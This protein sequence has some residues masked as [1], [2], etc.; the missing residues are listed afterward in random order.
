MLKSTRVIHDVVLVGGSTRIPRVHQLLRNFFN[1][2]E[3]CKSTNPDEA[4]AYGA[5]VQAAILGSEGNIEK[6]K[7][8]SSW[9]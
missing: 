6:V 4:V 5:A 9:M 3:L 8:Y 2:K 7:T 1:G